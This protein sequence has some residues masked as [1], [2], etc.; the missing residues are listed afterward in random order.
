MIEYTE[1]D[2]NGEIMNDEYV[3]EN[4]LVDAVG[5]GNL[6][7]VKELIAQGAD[8]N[9]RDSE[10][11]F[12][13]FNGLAET[14]EH[15]IVVNY[16]LSQGI[17]I[18]FDETDGR[19]LL[20]W[21]SKH[22]Y[23][24]LVKEMVQN[25]AGING[26]IRFKRKSPLHI[27][28]QNGRLE[29]VEFLVENG[30]EVNQLCL[31]GKTPL[32]YAAED[33]RTFTVRYLCSLPDCNVNIR[34]KDGWTPIYYAAEKGYFNVVKSLMENGADITTRDEFGKTPKDIA[35]DFNQKDILN[36]LSSN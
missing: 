21:A 34:D 4:A 30:A 14:R 13:L 35:V 1:K 10:G 11:R 15:Y 33:G 9:Y 24:D 6:N 23:I 8:I 7:E 32:H 25:G 28:A 12:I 22:G 5:K 19:L 20:Y 26:V 36:Y 27:A 2:K 31:H 29:V 3:L 17:F 16:I 18:N